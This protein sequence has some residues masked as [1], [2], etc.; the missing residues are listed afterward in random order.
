MRGHK[1]QSVSFSDPLTLTLSRGGEGT[2]TTPS[3]GRRG[4]NLFEYL[5]LLGLNR[6]QRGGSDVRRYACVAGQQGGGGK[7]KHATGWAVLAH[8]VTTEGAYPASIMPLKFQL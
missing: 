2:F 7:L 8:R 4:H 3:S 6:N 5:V 1:N